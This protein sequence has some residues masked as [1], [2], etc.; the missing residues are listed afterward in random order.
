M[1]D[2]DIAL[3]RR[4][5]QRP[6]LLAARSPLTVSPLATGDTAVAALN[7]PSPGP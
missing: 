1:S 3:E 7:G 2:N 4:E 5:A 6:A